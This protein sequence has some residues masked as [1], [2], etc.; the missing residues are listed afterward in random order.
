LGWPATLAAVTAGEGSV[1]VKTQQ[2]AHKS[3]MVQCIHAATMDF[4]IFVSFALE[5]VAA[6]AAAHAEYKSGLLMTPLVLLQ[7]WAML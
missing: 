1:H 3:C 5:L 2:A 6:A 7:T 4:L